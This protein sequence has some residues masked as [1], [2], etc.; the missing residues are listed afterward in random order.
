MNSNENKLILNDRL[1][2]ILANDFKNDSY[3]SFDFINID[4]ILLNDI[5]IQITENVLVE[6]ILNTDFLI[7]QTPQIKISIKYE[8][9]SNFS[10][11]EAN[12]V[13]K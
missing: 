6:I 10:I 2:Q 1:D 7:I 3:D 13:H 12:N 8:E 9:I 5:Y 11:Q 4:F